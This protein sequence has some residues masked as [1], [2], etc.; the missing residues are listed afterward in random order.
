MNTSKNRSAYY[1]PVI[2]INQDNKEY[3]LPMNVL[4]LEVVEEEQEV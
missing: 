2:I 3:Q 4:R 1:E